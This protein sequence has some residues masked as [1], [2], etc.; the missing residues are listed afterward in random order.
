MNFRGWKRLFL[1]IFEQVLDTYKR[2][3][4]LHIRL[5][6]PQICTDLRGGQKFVE[7]RWKSACRWKRIYPVTVDDIGLC[8][9]VITDFSSETQGSYPTS[10]SAV[11]SNNLL[12]IFP[13]F[14]SFLACVTRSPAI[15]NPA[16]SKSRK[17]PGPIGSNRPPWAAGE[18]VIDWSTESTVGT[19]NCLF[20][21]NA[22][23]LFGY[24]MG[25]SHIQAWM[26][27]CRFMLYIDRVFWRNFIWFQFNNGWSKCCKWY[28]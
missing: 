18:S 19:H 3:T 2:H 13:S 15:A 21:T 26:Y 6:S 20:G 27:K 17:N 8:H 24:W 23:R 16:T 28:G 14:P 4:P 7:N 5:L 9:W 25:S 1:T 10:Q 12:Y 11:S 22:W